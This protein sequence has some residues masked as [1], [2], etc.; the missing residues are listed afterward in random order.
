[1]STLLANINAYYAHTA[2]SSAVSAS[3]RFAA[4]NF[5]VSFVIG[6]GKLSSNKNDFTFWNL[7]QK[8]IIEV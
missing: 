7:I 1:M 4:S 3:D 5:G 6:I 2:A 8:V